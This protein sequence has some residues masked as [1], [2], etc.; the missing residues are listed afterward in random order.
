MAQD[1]NPA[2]GFTESPL[3]I[4]TLDFDGVALA[5][6]QGLCKIVKENEKEDTQEIQQ[7]TQK[8]QHLNKDFEQQNNEYDLRLKELEKIISQK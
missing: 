1:F 5:A 3:K 4:S 6:I 8:I 2:F 7:L